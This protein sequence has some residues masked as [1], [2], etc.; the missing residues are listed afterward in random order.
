[1]ANWDVVINKNIY[2]V[3]ANTNVCGGFLIHHLR[4]AISTLL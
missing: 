1:M 3:E 4:H 2:A